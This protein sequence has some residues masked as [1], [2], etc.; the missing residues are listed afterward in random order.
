MAAIL[1]QG[2]DPPIQA[3]ED[4]R[5]LGENVAPDAVR[6]WLIRNGLDV[7]IRNAPAAKAKE[8]G[9]LRPGMSIAFRHPNVGLC[10]LWQRGGGNASERTDRA[11]RGVVGPAVWS[12]RAGVHHDRCTGDRGSRFGGIVGRRRRGG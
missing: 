4:A 10:F 11:W 5:D 12:L 7:A 1:P 9:R 6:R 2:H 8:K 3:L